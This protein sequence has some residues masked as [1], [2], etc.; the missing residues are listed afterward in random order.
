MDNKYNKYKS[1]RGIKGYR[2]MVNSDYMLGIVGNG[3]VGKAMHMLGCSGIHIKCYDIN[4]LLCVPIGTSMTDLL[5]C[6]AIFISVPTPIDGEGKT[7][8]KYVDNVVFSLRELQYNGFIVIRSTVPIG[9]CDYYKCYFMPEFLT[10][11]NATN[12]FINNSNWIFG[13]YD[14]ERKGDFI[15]LMTNIIYTAFICNKIKSN[16]TTFMHNREAEM[17]KYFR[18]TFLATKISFCNE[19]YNLCM[20]KG[21][22][23]DRMVNIASDDNRI[24]KSHTSVPGHDGKFGFGGTCFPKDISSLHMQM[25]EENVPHHIIK[26]VIY[27]NNNIDRS[28]R[29]WMNDFGRTYDP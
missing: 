3:F 11:K 9:T 13:Y 22:D 25:E 24:S 1:I 2:D 5:D 29:D 19:I 20:K 8:M 27:R 23:Y 12:D 6:H 21:I 28:E 17:V 18:N 7:N 4:P 26:A 16:K 14:D 10:E 15:N